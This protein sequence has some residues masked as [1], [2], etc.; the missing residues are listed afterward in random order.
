MTFQR[1]TSSPFHYSCSSSLT[2]CLNR[3]E[4]VQVTDMARL[5]SNFSSAGAL[6]VLLAE[7]AR[8][9]YQEQFLGRD[10]SVNWGYRRHQWLCHPVFRKRRSYSLKTRS[11]PRLIPVLAP[12]VFRNSPWRRTRSRGHLS[13]RKLHL[14]RHRLPKIQR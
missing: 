10:Y 9:C 8:H 1:T 3:L 11:S 2:I 5:Y 7:D 6:Q 13:V 14:P 12:P 4:N